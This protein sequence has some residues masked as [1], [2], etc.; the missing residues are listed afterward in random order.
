M[1][2]PGSR[3]YI[4]WKIVHPSLTGNCTIRMGNSADED[5]LQV[6]FPTDKSADSKGSFPCGRAETGIEGKE[7]KLPSNITCDQCAL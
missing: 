7:V 4:A 6:L 2:T 1:A 5:E 3:N